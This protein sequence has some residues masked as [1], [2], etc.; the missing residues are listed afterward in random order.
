MKTSFRNKVAVITG[1]GAGIG[2]A[3]AVAMAHEGARLALSDIDAAG[4][5]RTQALLPAGTEVRT[6]RLNVTDE[7]A[8]FAHAAEVQRDFGAAHLLFNNA[9]SALLGTF[10]NQTLDEARWLIDLDLWSVVYCTKA[11]L[12]AMRQ[13]NEGWIVNIS[14]IAGLIGMPG[15]NTY[16]LVKFAVRGL[17]ESLWAELEGSGIQAVCVHPG[18]IKTNIERASRHCQKAGAIEERVDAANKR[19]LV[20]PPEQCAAD[21]INGLKAGKRRILTGKRS[22]TIDWIAR[23]LPNAYPR[24]INALL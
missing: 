20:T 1:A 3:L 9:G 24:L 11:F 21:I 5:A 13:Q 2:Q 22:S 23:L 6:Y 8:V 4:L 7:A 10:D 16:N 17:T 19:I 18:G 12:P 14:S 15:L